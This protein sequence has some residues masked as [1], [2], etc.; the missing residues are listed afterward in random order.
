MHGKTIWPSFCECWIDI[1]LEPPDIT[2][3]GAEM[4][5]M[6]S[7]FQENADMLL[8]RTKSVS[9]DSTKSMMIV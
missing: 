5:L 1:Y 9:V 3:N 2:I 8:L 6:A 7:P 4:N